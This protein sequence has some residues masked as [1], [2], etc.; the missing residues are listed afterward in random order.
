MRKDRPGTAGLPATLRNLRLAR[1]LTQ[2]ELA[3]RAGVDRSY[4]SRLERGQRANPSQD[5]LA[6]LA[7]VLGVPLDSFLAETAATWD[8]EP[9]LADAELELLFASVRRLP[10]PD[11]R[12]LKQILRAALELARRRRLGP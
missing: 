3:A 5:V 6:A 11:R 10:E 8:S 7:R 4:V 2:A 12:C 1:G 9:P